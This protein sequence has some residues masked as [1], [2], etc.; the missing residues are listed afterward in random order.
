MDVANCLISGMITLA[1]IG[2]LQI[3]IIE[4]RNLA[5]PEKSTGKME[6][7]AVVQL[8]RQRMKTR[9]VKDSFSPRWAQVLHS[10]SLC[11]IKR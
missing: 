7:F 5:V 4:G 11:A 6:V 3:Y 10:V 2:T 1:P 9:M 8:N